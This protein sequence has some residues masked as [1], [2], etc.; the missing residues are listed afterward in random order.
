MSIQDNLMLFFH[1]KQI[2][3]NEIFIWG[4]GEICDIDLHNYPCHRIILPKELRTSVS[5][6]Q[7]SSSWGEGC[8]PG[9]VSSLAQSRL[10]QPERTCQ[11]REVDAGGSSQTQLVLEWQRPE[12]KVGQS[13]VQFIITYWRRKWQPTPVLLPGKSH[14]QR[15]LVGYSLRGHKESDMT[16]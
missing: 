7:P 15:S 3:F 4:A 8:S 2:P 10:L 6:S 1:I 5:V 13:L 16:E 12:E 14:G 11:P 9:S